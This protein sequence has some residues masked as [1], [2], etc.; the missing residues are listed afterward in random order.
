MLVNVSSS[1]V[2]TDSSCEEI[3]T[4]TLLPQHIVVPSSMTRFSFNLSASNVGEPVENS[5]AAVTT[6]NRKINKKMKSGHTKNN[7]TLES[8]SHQRQ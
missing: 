2:D 1:K 5:C 7:H 8:S 3:N 4:H 6:T